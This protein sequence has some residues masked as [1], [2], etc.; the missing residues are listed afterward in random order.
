M[1]EANPDLERD[2]CIENAIK[3]VEEGSSIRKAASKWGVPRST[4]QDKCSGRTKRMRCGPLPFI[5]K[6]EEERL[7]TWLVERAKC[8]FGL[9]VAE[10][11]DSVKRFLDKDNRKTPFKDN[12]PGRKWFRSFIKRNPQVRLRNA[13]PLDKKRA[14]ISAKDVDQWFTEYEKFIL[15]NGLSNKAAQIWNCD[16]SG[17]NLQ[18][19]AGKVLGPSAPKVQPYRVVTGTKEHITVLPCFN[20]AGQFIPPFILFSGKRAPVGYNPLEGAAPGSAFAVTEKGYMDAPTFYLWLANHFIPHLPP[21]RPV[22]LLVDSAEAHIDIHTFELAKKN[23][24]Y[25]FA[26]LKNATHL[27]QP[28]DV[29]LFGPL[30]QAWYKAVRRFTQHNPNTDITK[31]NFSS[32]FKTTWQ[33]V[34]RPS[35]LCDAF[36]KSGVYPLRREQITDDQTRSSLIY[37]SSS[38]TV[39]WNVVESNHDARPAHVP[40][41]SA[42]SLQSDQTVSCDAPPI[43]LAQESAQ[44]ASLDANTSPLL[45]SN[46]RRA[47]MAPP[48]PLSHVRVESTSYDEEPIP[49]LEDSGLFIAN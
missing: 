42:S 23:N 22:V 49:L 45:Q 15:E 32:V 38:V 34:M 39:T 37:S 6:A 36:R 40:E 29:G 3:E 28:A 20:A 44:S 48:A 21:A 18:G 41:E 26:L 33:D 9:T 46:Q 2:K 11:L 24:I 10:F 14:K 1:A 31:K 43:P 47:S 7:A 25:I 17:F 16:E 5:T 13:R 35:I 8:G 19:K 4:V 12:R 27:L 30:K